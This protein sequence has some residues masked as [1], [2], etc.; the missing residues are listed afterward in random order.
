MRNLCAL[1]SIVFISTGITAII[2][3]DTKALPDIELMPFQ[4]GSDSEINLYIGGSLGKVNYD[5]SFDSEALSLDEGD[6]FFKLF[7]GVEFGPHMALE[8]GYANLDGIAINTNVDGNYTRYSSEDSFGLFSNVL[9]RMPVNDFLSVHGKVGL[10]AWFESNPD[11]YNDR[12][13]EYEEDSFL[14]QVFYEN[15]KFTPFIGLGA[16]AKF[17]RI[18]FR[19]DW[20]F[21]RKDEINI[22]HF[23]ISGIFHF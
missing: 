23:G 13:F 6:Q 16:A 22:N 7:T 17:D 18:E 15:T 1:P 3:F 5:I 21:L 10:Y 19:A 20:E 2:A 14:E 12:Q 4:S 11:Y 8:L 9:L